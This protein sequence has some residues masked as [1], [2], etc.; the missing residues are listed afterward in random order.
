MVLFAYVGVV[1][2]FVGMDFFNT[3]NQCV[4]SYDKADDSDLC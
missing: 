2:F 4:D 1:F 3:I